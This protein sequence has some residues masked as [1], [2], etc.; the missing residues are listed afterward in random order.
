MGRILGLDYGQKRIGVALS[1]PMGV[2]AQ[3]LTTLIYQHEEEVVSRVAEIISREGVKKIVVG[4]P[5]NLKGQK[6]IKAQATERFIQRL[7][8]RF[9]LPVVEWDER[10]TTVAA[11]RALRELGQ[12]PSRRRE[13][14]DELSAVFI[15]QA[16]LDNL[17]R[18]N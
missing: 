17:K 2:T 13:K 15:L 16:Y 9:N 4:M 5:L 11:H 3:G 10:L 18:S 8:K 12:S 7:R 14:V 1:D 6:G